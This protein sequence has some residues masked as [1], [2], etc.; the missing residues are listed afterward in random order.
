MA[1]VVICLLTYKRTP[2]AVATIKAMRANFKCAD[3]AW[4]VADGGSDEAHMQAIAEALEGAPLLGH[5]SDYESP[6]R[7]MNRAMQ[8]AMQ[9]ANYIFW[10]EDDWVLNRPLDIDFWI[11]KLDATP[12]VGMI[13][14]G[15]LGKGSDVMIETLVD[16]HC[17]RFLR[18]TPYAYAGGPSLRTKQ[19]AEHYGQFNEKT[20]VGDTEVEYDGRF[21]MMA[22]PEI[23]WPIAGTSGWGWFDHIGEKRAS[24]F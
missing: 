20:S 8:A 18:S 17:L 23:V 15:Y 6:G 24:E 2:Y 9:A 10:L 5:H 19:F 4:Y 13:R 7:M 12:S 16:Y 14:F 3:Y 1:K 21:R 11:R 22:G